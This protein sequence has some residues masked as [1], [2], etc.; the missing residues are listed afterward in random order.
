MTLGYH[1]MEVDL[2]MILHLVRPSVTNV[3]LVIRLQEAGPEAVQPQV[4]GA[5]IRLLVQVSIVCFL[6]LYSYP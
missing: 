6:N 4:H 1:P 3:A 2:V 5:G